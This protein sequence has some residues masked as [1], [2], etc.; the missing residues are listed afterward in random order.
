MLDNSRVM[1]KI[2]PR[3][4]GKIGPTLGLKDSYKDFKN[5]EK[6]GDYFKI[7]YKTYRAVCESFNKL[8]VEDIL[9]NT[10][11]F[12]LP[13]RLGSIRIQKKKMNFTKEALKVDWK[14]SRELGK[15]V[16]HMN[17]HSDNY[18][19]KWYWKKTN[20]IVQNK[21]LYSFTASRANKREL[22]RIIKN[23]KSIDYFE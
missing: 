9:F 14:A 2:K 17:D 11:E 4:K 3:T 13:H 8:T 10:G 23:E 15:R 5:T 22:A 1:K 21:S 18:R 6:L 16:Y 12:K 19:Y 7:D 20:A